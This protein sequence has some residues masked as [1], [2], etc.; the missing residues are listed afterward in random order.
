MSLD[1][2]GIDP[3]RLLPQS[4]EDRLLGWLGRMGGIALLAVLAA[5][6][7]CLASWSFSDPSLSHATTAEP[8]N[9]LGPLG[10]IVADLLLQPF[11]F[12]AVVALLA[13][14]LWSSEMIFGRRLSNGRSKVGFYPLSILAVSGALS[15]LP[16]IES[17][18]LNHG[19][20]GALGDA[21]Y[22]LVGNLFG[23]INQDRADLAAALV[24]FASAA[25]LLAKSLGTDIETLL[26]ELTRGAPASGSDA[27]SA[28]DA[29]RA[30]THDDDAVAVTA[31]RS[32]AGW[33]RRFMRRGKPA[34]HASPFGAADELAVPHEH[35]GYGYVTMGEPTVGQPPVGQPQMGHGWP[36]A[37]FG[38]PAHGY[39]PAPFAPHPMHGAPGN[40]YPQA[41]AH[42]APFAAAANGAGPHGGPQ[43]RPGARID[44][45]IQPSAMHIGT[46]SDDD[47]DRGLGFDMSTDVS[48]RKIA[49]RFAP[50]ANEA[51][52]PAP[53]LRDRIFPKG[54]KVAGLADG[55]D[56]SPSKPQWKRPSLNLLK[57]PTAAKPGP[58][59]TQT[60]MRGNARLL[61]DVLADFGVKGEVKDI[62]PGPV[63]T[64]YELEPARGTKSARVIGLA[65]D[66]ARSMSVASVRAA[67]VAGRNAI[68]LELP[69]MRREP[70][71][72][73]EL[74]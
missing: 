61:E 24:L 17:W 60:V 18:P 53:P 50:V 12:A 19:Y 69:N 26:R 25:G 9:W 49:E 73:R 15:S 3:D 8:R 28:S 45:S 11:G 33:L 13:P 51:P 59:F 68:G 22:G 54:H 34:A 46:R 37:E 10:A 27:A 6:W 36:S 70:V 32:K 62:R 74:L 48:S 44:D 63:V 7:V 64:L 43:M 72:L 42:P 20:G 65:D 39:A 58:E 23:L 52:A 1:T 41:L 71:L 40:G 2:R 55:M 4:L 21:L 16:M 5:V 14:M 47:E 67:V 35:A 56:F 31:S 29:H 30:E 38:R 57:K 66:I